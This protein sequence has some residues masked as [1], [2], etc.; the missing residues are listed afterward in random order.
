MSSRFLGQLINGPLR[1][2]GLKLTRSRHLDDCDAHIAKLAAAL[3][4]ASRQISEHRQ[5]SEARLSALEELQRRLTHAAGL[6]L[7]VYLTNDF[8]PACQLAQG[9]SPH[10]I[11]VCSIPKA[12]TYLVDRLLE[13][14]D[15]V[16]SRLHLSSTI[17]TDYRFATVR[18]ARENYER[19]LIDVPLDRA[20]EL[21][22]PGQ[23]TVGHLECSDYV[24]QVLSKVKKVFVFRDLRD[25]VVSYLRFLA[26]TGRGGE[27]TRAWRDLQ[28]GP[29]QMLRFLDSSGQEYFRMTLP[30]IDWLDQPDAFFI[31]FETLYGDAGSDEQQSLIE[32]LHGFLDL[33][34]DVPDIESLCRSLIG[35]PTMTWSGG[36]VSRETY[37]N[38]EVE[39][40]FEA[41][42][43]VEA[44]RRLGYET[45]DAGHVLRLPNVTSAHRRA[46]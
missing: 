33:P 45:S 20:V 25:G 10:R 22:L 23:F 42:G 38:D 39:Q 32:Q 13:L 26:S 16:P 46:A 31:S 17:L 36:R 9:A 21:L 4:D 5:E 11:V 2:V 8:Q 7:P 12:G 30:M 44:N 6:P 43:G 18:E 35:A 3:E 40:R 34:G 29:E 19:L 28:P 37:W 15:C 14:L 24:R 1:K 41:F 27:A